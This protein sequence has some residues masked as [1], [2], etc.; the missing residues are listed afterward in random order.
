MATDE[1][2]ANC[3]PTAPVDSE[4]GYDDDHLNCSFDISV[5]GNLTE[6]YKTVNRGGYFEMSLSLT[7]YKEF[8]GSM[9]IYTWL[10]HILIL[11]DLQQSD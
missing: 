2:L 4:L 11:M 9:L 5:C 8:K 7:T 3:S 10:W 1:Y 6:D